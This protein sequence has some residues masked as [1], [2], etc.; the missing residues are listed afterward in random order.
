M[1]PTVQF[2][3][4]TLAVWTTTAGLPGEVAERAELLLG[5]AFNSQITGLKSL[6]D[7]DGWP[8]SLLFALVTSVWHEKRHFFD[9]L[10]TNY[11]AHRFR[12]AFVFAANYFPLQEHAIHAD[13]GKIWFPVETYACPFRRKLNGIATP[14]ANVL[15]VAEYCRA[16]KRAL[17]SLDSELV[18]KGRSIPAGGEAQLE[19]LA[20][21]SQWHSIEYVCDPDITFAKQR[22]F[23]EMHSP[24]GQYRMVERVA[25]ALGCT[26]AHGEDVIANPGLASAIYI[27]SLSGRYIGSPD[28]VGKDLSLPSVRFG[29]LMEALL[30]AGD[31]EMT[32]EEAWELVDAKARSFWGRTALEE[33]EAEIDSMDEALDEV[34]WLEGT[35]LAEVWN[36]FIRLRR[37]AL[38]FVKDLGPGSMGPRSFP[39]DWLSKLSPWR[40]IATPAGNGEDQNVAFGRMLN[41]PKGMEGFF[42]PTVVWGRLVEPRQDENALQVGDRESWQHMIEW[43]APRAL[44]MEN[45]R[46]HRLLVPRQLE[47]SL[48]A[49][50]EEGLQPKFDP[51]FEFPAM[52]DN[53][54]RNREAIELAK[55]S[56]RDHF[57]CDLT[58]KRIVPDEAALLT[59]WE[60]RQS[61]LADVPDSAKSIEELVD[62][63]R[64][65]ADWSDWVVDLE[66]LGE[67][68]G[69]ISN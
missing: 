33:I 10:I 6:G 42:P 61:G 16:T 54:T 59:P 58:G 26:K 11:G 4:S 46:R 15:A 5:D 24:R 60:Y 36:D 51:M 68:D 17:H 18:F 7:S 19:A 38:S 67:K 27:T 14:S 22:Q 53:E 8:E 50:S 3:P 31:Y 47:R 40:I 66:L 63:V 37:M 55:W 9:T 43:H 12:R 32:D 65:I 52:R 25:T 23:A 29:S 48:E 39:V 69:S 44:L 45:G 30:E 13:S 2:D 49:M 35:G 1:L 28:D 21:S 57:N 64:D 56:N 41:L 62:L 20:Q 34:P